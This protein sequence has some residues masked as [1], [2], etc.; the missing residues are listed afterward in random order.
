MNLEVDVEVNRIYL[1]SLQVDFCGKYD[2]PVGFNSGSLVV[3]CFGVK[4]YNFGGIN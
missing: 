2:L 1:L 3:G 4:V